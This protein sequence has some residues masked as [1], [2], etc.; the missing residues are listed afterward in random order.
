M[1]K[2]YPKN[3]ELPKKGGENQDKIIGFYKKMLT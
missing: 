1:E 3:T 2:K